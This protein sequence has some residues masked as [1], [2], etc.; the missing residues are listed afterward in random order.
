MYRFGLLLATT[1]ALLAFPAYGADDQ[2]IV[3]KSAHSVAQTID[4][5]VD[6]LKQRGVAV[7]ARVNHAAA[8]QNVGQAL[9]PTELVMFGNPKLGTP[10]MQA[11]RKVGLELPMKVLAW[12]DD[13]G[14]VWLGYVKPERLKAEYSISGRDDVFREMATAL[15]RLTDEASKPN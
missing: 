6:A 15:D 3:K 1:V 9:K 10:L 4:R 7:V 12:E 5:L 11:N 14:Q 13:G 8:A 2:L